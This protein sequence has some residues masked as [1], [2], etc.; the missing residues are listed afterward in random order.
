MIVVIMGVSGSGK[1][2]VGRLLARRL[3]W[4]FY[5]GD[6]FHSANNI[7]KMSKGISLTDEDRQPW[8][9]SLRMVIEACVKDGIDAVLACSALR[10]RYRTFLA[11]GTPDIRFVYLKGDV[12]IIRERMS[13]RPTHYM[14]A[15]MLDSQVASLE[16]PDD[17]VVGD[18]RRSPREIVSRVAR[19]LGLVTNEER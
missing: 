13:S 11:A 1:S 19:E 10:A 15:D 3:G 8:L 16:E 2:T 5:E 9:E 4:K 18:I 7:A 17:A 14:K 6:E 12:S